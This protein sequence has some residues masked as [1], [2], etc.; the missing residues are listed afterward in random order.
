M[1]AGGRAQEAGGKALALRANV[2]RTV[3]V[4]I[5]SFLLACSFPLPPQI[6]SMEGASAAWLALIPLILL[7]R[8]SR[9][10]VAFWWGWLCGFLFWMVSAAWVLQLRHTWGF[11]P[12]VILAWMAM[13]AYCGIY[14]GLFAAILSSV[15]P[16]PPNAGDASAPSQL[17]LRRI[18]LVLL[19]PIIWVGCEYVRA[20]LFT[21]FPWNVLGV[22]QYRNIAILQVAS[23]GG[24]YAVSGIIVLLSAAIA[25]TILRI[26]SELRQRKRR[27]VHFELM[28]GLVAVALCWSWGVR[29]V[30][31]ADRTPDHSPRVRIAAVQPYIQ[32]EQKWSEAFRE[33][34]YQALEEQTALA[35]LSRPALVI[36]PETAVPD[37]LRVDPRA[38]EVV[39]SLVSSNT[40]LLVGTMDFEQFDEEV[41]YY[42]GSFLVGESGDVLGSY[43]K[44][45]LV[46]FG[47]YIP[48]ENQISAIKRLAPLG[49]SCMPGGAYSLMELPVGDAES[50]QSALF[51]DLIC[52]ED[53]FPYLAR[54]DVRAGA[55]FLVNQTN[56]AW[57]E[58]S[59]ASRQHMANAVFR[60]VENR[61]PLVRCAN[62]GVTCFVDRFGRILEMLEGDDGR[63]A[64]RG[65]SVSEV[66]VPSVDMPLTPYTRFGD[67]L[68]ARPCA[69]IVIG[70]LLVMGVRAHSR[71]R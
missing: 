33:G 55:R 41:F 37:L 31:R 1:S 49:F 36:W 13:A 46:P 11:L 5:S 60:A 44:R 59:A 16:D 17:Q 29:S 38:Q 34:A 12:V 8:L 56:D 70:L 22:S 10:K 58:G 42:N 69:I 24:A 66:H 21:G 63:T 71:R 7:S 3:A 52:F 23:W 43:H 67:W 15:L 54:Q 57:F 18:V 50:G 30:R 25:V 28:L 51:S 6:V 4:L 32:Q 9:P 14:I 39:G 48:F 26:G 47:E 65:F 61:V 27:R 19:T 62:T 2:L 64:L 45:H 68:F 35:L 40:M 20:L 53:V